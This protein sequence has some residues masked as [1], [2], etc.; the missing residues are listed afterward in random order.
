MIISLLRSGKNDS[1]THS[2]CGYSKWCMYV[3]MVFLFVDLSQRAQ[4]KEKTTLSS[5]L[6]DNNSKW[7]RSMLISVNKM[8]LV[9]HY[10]VLCYIII[11]M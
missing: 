3:L 5:L 2:A 11:G 7:I 1:S 9:L 4:E 10:I 8:S 6:W